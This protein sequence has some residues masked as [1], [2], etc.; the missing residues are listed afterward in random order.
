MKLS[1]RS[2]KGNQSRTNNDAMGCYQDSDY[3]VAVVVDASEKGPEGA[4]YALARFWVAE[5]ISS[6]QSEL[7]KG[8]ELSSRMLFHQIREAHPKLRPQHLYAIASYTVLGFNKCTGE[9]LILYCGDCLVAIESPSGELQWMIEPHHCSRQQ[10]LEGALFLDSRNIL[11]RCL[12]ARR[13][14]GPTIIQSSL[15]GHNKVLICTDGYWA[16]HLSLKQDWDNLEDDASVLLISPSENVFKYT[17]ESNNDN[18][19][20]Q[21]HLA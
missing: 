15:C 21:S 5:L 3:L 14:E 18:G 20:F 10:G 6:I 7:K 12:K 8:S 11:T 17:T 13:F 19:F 4:G 2:R 16:E 9:L 1:W